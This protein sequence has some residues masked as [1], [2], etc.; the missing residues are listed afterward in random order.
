[1]ERLSLVTGQLLGIFNDPLFF[2]IPKDF[3]STDCMEVIGQISC[4]YDTDVVKLS[5]SNLQEIKKPKNN[6]IFA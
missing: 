1:M 5:R 2:Y 6:K 3:L 4:W